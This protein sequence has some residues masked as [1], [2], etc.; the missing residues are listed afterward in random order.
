MAKLVKIGDL[1]QRIEFIGESEGYQGDFGWV[2]GKEEVKLTCWASIR[3]QYLNERLATI[4]TVLEDTVTFII[5]YK[6]DVKVE[7]SF[8]IK[9]GSDVYEII[10]IHPDTNRKEFTTITAKKVGI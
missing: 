3:T 5:R 1:N 2:P 10:K 7:N 9:L 6:Q 4:G 8:K